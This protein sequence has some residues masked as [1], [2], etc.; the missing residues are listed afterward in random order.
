MAA[1]LLL[2]PS[3]VVNVRCFDVAYSCKDLHTW[4]LRRQLTHAPS[5]WE[6][7]ETS[8]PCKCIAGGGGKC[9]A[10]TRGDADRWRMTECLNPSKIHI[11][12]IAVQHS[13]AQLWASRPISFQDRHITDVA[14]DSS[15]SDGTKIPG[16]WTTFVEPAA[17]QHVTPQPQLQAVQTHTYS[18]IK[19]IALFAFAR[20][21]P[22][23]SVNS[24]ME[25][26]PAPSTLL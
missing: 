19:T 18:H 22:T 4:W 15:Y 3:A 24:T 16:R 13:G 8:R 25:A 21:S 7:K 26:E 9:I 12:V 10:A 2:S 5:W 11:T 6:C 20:R 23:S 14:A 17:S 1:Y